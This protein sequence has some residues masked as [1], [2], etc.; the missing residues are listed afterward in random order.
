MTNL[1]HIKLFESFN[2]ADLKIWF[3][4]FK[5]FLAIA[6]QEDAEIDIINQL[7]EH[8][9]IF[10]SEPENVYDYVQRWFVMNEKYLDK[11]LYT[12]T[13]ENFADELLKLKR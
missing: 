6:W 12:S 4:Q 9:E 10:T 13:S 2:R 7:S 3:D 5:N 8:K 1:K 11:V